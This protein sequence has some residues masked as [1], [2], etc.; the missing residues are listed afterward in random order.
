MGANY[1]VARKKTTAYPAVY[2]IGKEPDPT[3]RAY[4]EKFLKQPSFISDL[5][6]I[7]QHYL[8]VAITVMNWTLASSGRLAM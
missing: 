1:A 3:L 5:V 7:S 2:S 6:S 8:V 4:K